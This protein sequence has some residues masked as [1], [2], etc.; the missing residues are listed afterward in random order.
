MSPMR[1]RWRLVSLAP[2]VLGLSPMAVASLLSSCRDEPLPPVPRDEGKPL[3]GVAGPGLHVSPAGADT[4]DCRSYWCLTIDYAVAKA[5]PGEVISLAP[6]TYYGSLT[7]AKSL[8]IIGD[9]SAVG[10]AGQVS[11]QRRN[12]RP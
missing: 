10:P 12:G 5:Q 3:P 4:G 1:T 11:F 9:S 2:L 6:G 7:I 8:S